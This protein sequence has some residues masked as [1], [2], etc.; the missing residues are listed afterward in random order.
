MLLSQGV[1]G[2]NARTLTITP[3]PVGTARLLKAFFQPPGG[4]AN[5][6]ILSCGRRSGYLELNL[7]PDPRPRG[8]GWRSAVINIGGKP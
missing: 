7:T 2:G 8:F 4:L 1:G 5:Y 6:R 3:A